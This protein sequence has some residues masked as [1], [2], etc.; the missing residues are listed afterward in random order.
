[1]PGF[2]PERKCVILDVIES[3]DEWLEEGDDF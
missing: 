1:M 2:D 3:E